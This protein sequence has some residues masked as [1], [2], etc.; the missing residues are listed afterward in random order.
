M[1][2]ETEFIFPLGFEEPKEIMGYQIVSRIEGDPVIEISSERF[3][4]MWKD[5]YPPEPVLVKMDEQYFL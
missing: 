1:D 5:Q 2:K 4:V 3:R